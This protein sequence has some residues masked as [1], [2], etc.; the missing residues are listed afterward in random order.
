MGISEKHA[1]DVPLVL[2]PN[3]GK[4]TPQWN[5]IFDDW[6]STI[7]IEEE[8]LPDFHSEEWSKMFG[9]H[10][11][12]I[13]DEDEDAE[14]FEPVRPARPDLR[15][16]PRST[17]ED[18]RNHIRE[19]RINQREL[20][21]SHQRYQPRRQERRE[22]AEQLEHQS[23][24][25]TLNDG[26]VV[27]ERSVQSKSVAN[28]GD[29]RMDISPAT[30]KRKTKSSTPQTTNEKR[31]MTDTSKPHSAE[32]P[33]RD[34]MN[35]NNTLIRPRRLS[36][37]GSPQQQKLD[38][39]SD[40]NRRRSSRQTTQRKTL[41]YDHEHGQTTDRPSGSTE[42]AGVAEEELV[43]QETI[44]H[45]ANHCQ[46]YLALYGIKQ[47]READLD[48][49]AIVCLARLDEL[50]PHQFAQV[51]KAAKGKNL[52]ILSYEEAMSDYENLKDW[53]ASA[54]KEIRQLE[55]KGV[56]VECKK[57][58]AKGQQI[59][60]CTWVF[61]YK[62][63]PAG[64]IIKCKARIC[65]RGDLME[66]DSNTYAPVVQNPTIKGFI[67]TALK[68]DWVM[69]SVNWVNAFPQAKLKKPIFMHT[70]RGFKNRFGSNGCLRLGRSLYGSKF[71]PLNWYKH[72]L[73]AL[74]KLGFK[75]CPHDPCL[76]Y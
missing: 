1:G 14:D 9:L 59:I 25:K 52:D 19:V 70:P 72:L 37:E 36:M 67:T 58:E 16:G 34:H 28:E 43:N 21:Q 6:F 27:S 49:E 68:K 63:N 26:T 45:I 48:E 41:T 66:D 31:N 54:L 73:E 47:E 15:W 51:F 57:S 62:R 61:R 46:I 76:L 18:Q 24:A 10:T 56:W 20:N 7:T 69:I 42:L 22:Q 64:E 2:N 39:T 32:L 55:K 44:E 3:T 12:A 30:P 13:P 50:N 53:L 4:I 8:D 29:D 40:E 38:S 33:Y 5:V 75:Q 60:P 23:L 17:D 35:K 11:Y 71:A 74:L 65:L